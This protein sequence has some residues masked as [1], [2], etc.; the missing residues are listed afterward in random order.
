MTPSRIIVAWQRALTRIAVAAALLALLLSGM[1]VAHAVRLR[2]SN[3]WTAPALIT[4]KAEITKNGK[5]ELSETYRQLDAAYNARF[6]AAQAQITRGIPLLGGT[7]AV[8]LLAALLALLL[9]RKAIDPREV[10]APQPLRLAMTSR[11]AVGVMSIVLVGTLIGL[12]T[13]PAPLIP[14]N[15]GDGPRAAV[16]DEPTLA[17]APPGDPGTLQGLTPPPL[18]GLITPPPLLPPLPPL[19][20]APPLSP[21]PTQPVPTTANA[22]AGLTDVLAHIPET[23]KANWP[24]FRGPAG[25]GLAKVT[26]A[27]LQWNLKS[28]KGVRWHAEIP[29]P[30]NSSPIVWGDRVFVSGADTEHREIYCYD[31]GTGKLLWTGTTKGITGSEEVEVHQ[32]DTGYAAPTMATDGA[33]VFAI[34]ANGD[35]IG[36]D[37]TGKRLWGRSLGPIDSMYGYASSLTVYKELVIAQIDQAGADDGISELLALN[38]ATGETVWKVKSRPVPASWSSPIIIPTK[39]RDEL[40]TCGNPWVIA[41]DP[42]NGK[43]LWRAAVLEGDVAPTPTYGGGLLILCKPYSAVIALHPGGKG[44]VTKTAV[45]WIAE[46]GAPDTTSPVAT[47]DLLFIPNNSYLYCHDVKTG[48]KLWEHEL[49]SNVYASPVIATGRVYVL[50]LQGTMHIL[51]AARRPKL[52]GKVVMGGGGMATPAFV[53]GDMYLRLGSDLY[54]IGGGA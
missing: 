13:I 30:G 24:L 26:D 44:D 19:N 20:P 48:K 4:L 23:V 40:I 11:Y 41:Y 37:F 31:A 7:L 21:A 53:G 38:A 1:L 6:F 22:G 17:S 18:P 14:V 8:C 46:D 15:A 10:A 16:T 5:R 29:L 3:P 39:T 54:R 49:E 47:D 9:R 25:I 42:V 36:Y 2:A 28:G 27:P 32:A 45:A 33:R 34:F 43:E 52:L 51:S 12:A 35:I 50:D